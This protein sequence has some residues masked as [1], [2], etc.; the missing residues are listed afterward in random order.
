M[1]MIAIIALTLSRPLILAPMSAYE[2]GRLAG[3]IFIV[4]FIAAVIYEMVKKSRK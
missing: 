3:K 2:M 1:R 4:I